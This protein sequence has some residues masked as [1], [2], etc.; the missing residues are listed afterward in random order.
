VWVKV[1]VGGWIQ[2]GLG[3]LMAHLQLHSALC[4]EVAKHQHAN[5]LSR[6]VRGASFACMCSSA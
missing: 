5:Q 3:G 4:G 1:G 6:A 2:V